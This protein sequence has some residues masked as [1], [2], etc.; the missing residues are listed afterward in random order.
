MQD[1]YHNV[2]VVQPLN[3]VVSTTTKTSAAIDLQGFDSATV[4]FSLGATGDTLSGSIYWTLKLQHCDDDAS[5]EDVTTAGLLNS[6]ATIV[7]DSG[8]EDETAY[9]FGYL[10]G[11]R[12]VKAVATPTGSHSTGTPIGMLALKGHPS[13][14]PVI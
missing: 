5:Y 10:G 2:A 7:V 8:S 6:A 12:Y 13:R 14:A 4:I 1:L 11:K 3:P 9:L